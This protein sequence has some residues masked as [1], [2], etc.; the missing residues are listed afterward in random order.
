MKQASS[1]EQ[2]ISRNLAVKLF[3]GSRKSLE[4]AAEAGRWPEFTNGA[5]VMSNKTRSGGGVWKVTGPTE[6]A[7]REAVQALERNEHDKLLRRRMN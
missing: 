1:P 4:K 7:V 5:K 3:G 6:Q 2:K